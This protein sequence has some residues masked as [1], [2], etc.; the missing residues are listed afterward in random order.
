M[1]TTL[2]HTEKDG[3]TARALW[4]VALV[5][6]ATTLVAAFLGGAL[7]ARSV[8]LGAIVAA[9]NLWVITVVVRG[10]LGGKKSRVPW[11]LI[12]MLKMGVLFG[13]LYLF[14][15]SGWVDLLPLL[16]GYGA[17]P[18]GIVAGQLGAPRPIEEEG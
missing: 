7:A 2:T 9:A 13:G 5:G 4:A 14:L 16:A 3:S 8:A 6:T 15:K 12:A 17:L 10:M 1:T 18:L 11:P